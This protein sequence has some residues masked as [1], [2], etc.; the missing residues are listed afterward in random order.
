[1]KQLSILT[2][3]SQKKYIRIIITT[4]AGLTMFACRGSRPEKPTPVT[5]ISTLKRVCPEAWYRNLMPGI[6]KTE[7]EEYLV[8]NG[9]RAEI[10]DYD[11]E[12]IRKNCPIK[13]PSEVH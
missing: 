2:E 13:G 3:M 8:V 1:M 12:W 5:E 4:I 6:G 11:V 10:R 7:P 9:I